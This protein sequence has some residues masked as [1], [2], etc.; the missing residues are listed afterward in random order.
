MCGFLFLHLVC[1][2]CIV[3]WSPIKGKWHFIADNH[4]STHLSNFFLVWLKY[5]QV[6]VENYFI[7]VHVLH[8]YLGSMKCMK[9]LVGTK[10]L[11]ISLLREHL[12]H[13]PKIVKK[14][15]TTE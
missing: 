7:L 6:F 3:V 12:L 14:V 10:A 11:E 15:W 9:A 13:S 8:I 5:R 2:A 1:V 4:L